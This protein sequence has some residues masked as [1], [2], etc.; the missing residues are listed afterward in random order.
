MVK[1]LQRNGALGAC[2]PI[3]CLAALMLVPG[4]AAG[5]PPGTQLALALC[6]PDRNTFSVQIDNPYFPLPVGREWVLVGNDQG[7][8]IGLRVTVLNRRET[9]RCG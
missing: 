1:H 2:T 9:F 7:Q 8:T 5:A 3:V 4:S 6:A